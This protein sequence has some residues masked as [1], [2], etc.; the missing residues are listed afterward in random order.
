MGQINLAIELIEE[1]VRRYEAE[2]GTVRL[3]VRLVDQA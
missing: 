2:A 3:A 1:G